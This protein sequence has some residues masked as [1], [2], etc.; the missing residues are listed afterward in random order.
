MWFTGLGVGSLDLQA[1]QVCCMSVED[2][3][4]YHKVNDSEPMVITTKPKHYSDTESY[5]SDGEHEAETPV[6]DDEGFD[7]LFVFIL[8]QKRLTMAQSL[9]HPGI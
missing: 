9:S 2:V 3:I 8:S 7:C 4:D 1:H 6:A 5:C